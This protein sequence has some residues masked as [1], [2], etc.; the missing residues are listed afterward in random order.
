MT[1]AGALVRQRRSMP[2]RHCAA[3]PSSWGRRR[4]CE[5]AVC[6]FPPTGCT[7]TTPPP[8]PRGAQPPVG[9]SCGHPLPHAHPTRGPV[10]SS[11]HCRIPHRHTLPALLRGLRPLPRASVAPARRLHPGLHLPLPLQVPRGL[12]P[13]RPCQRGGRRRLPAAQARLGR[14]AQLRHAALRGAGQHEDRHQRVESRRPALDRNLCVAVQGTAGPL[15]PLPLILPAT[16]AP[17]P[18]VYNRVALRHGKPTVV[19]Q[20][21]SFF[22]S[23]LWHVRGCPRAPPAATSLTHPPP[24]AGPA[25]WILPLLPHRCPVHF[26]VTGCAA[27]A[28]CGLAPAVACRP[29]S[30]RPPP[31]A[32]RYGDGSGRAWCPTTA[33]SEI[34]LRTHSRSCARH[35]GRARKR[36]RRPPLSGSP[37]GCTTRRQRRARGSCSTTRASPSPSSALGP[38]SACG[39]PSGSSGTCSRPP[40]LRSCASCPRPGSRPPSRRSR[41]RWRGRRRRRRSR[42]RS[43]SQVEA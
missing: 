31:V 32:Q 34:A 28:R 4:G 15:A 10:P 41:E 6:G 17:L 30:P 27:A 42:R 19:S 16:P 5:T 12:G 2:Q 40:R 38:P 1:P 36:R 26:S 33:A 37:P 3:P 39:R 21:L 7:Y 25:P 14:A 29:S 13:G 9:S 24:P 35:A 22:L 23:A 43:S 11:Q 18:D 20:A 8:S